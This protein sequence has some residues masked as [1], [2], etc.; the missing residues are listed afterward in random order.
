MDAKDEKIIISSTMV[1]IIIQLS[2]WI[3]WGAYYTFTTNQNGKLLEE[4]KNEN[5]PTRIKVL[6]V[7]VEYYDRILERLDS[8]AQ[9]INELKIEQQKGRP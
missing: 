8:L 3:F 5:L 1:T 4:L 6:E 2:L 9:E 7:K